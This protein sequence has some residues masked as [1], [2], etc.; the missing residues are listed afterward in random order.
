MGE[1]RGDPKERTGREERMKFCLQ[2]IRYRERG[3]R[4]ARQGSQDR[5]GKEEVV[6]CQ[7][8]GKV[9]L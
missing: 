8:G 2:I 4:G 7:P 3:G 1:K 6:H 9:N 5:V